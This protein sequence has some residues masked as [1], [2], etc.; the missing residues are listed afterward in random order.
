MVTE[1][2]TPIETRVL[3]RGNFLDEKGDIVE[4][5]VPH[6][7]PQPPDAGKHRLTRL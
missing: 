2:K 5:S 3:A 4:P 7:L 6:F 1:A